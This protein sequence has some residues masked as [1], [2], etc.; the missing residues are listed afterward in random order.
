MRYVMLHEYLSQYI[1]YI[2]LNCERHCIV[3]KTLW[4]IALL[5]SPELARKI[6]FNFTLT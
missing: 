5:P 1:I 2:S 4:I 3:R 6:T